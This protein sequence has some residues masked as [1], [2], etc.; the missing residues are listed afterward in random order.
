M[1]GFNGKYLFKLVKL[2]GG[3]VK[4]FDFININGSL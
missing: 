2:I 3:L 4:G 1:A